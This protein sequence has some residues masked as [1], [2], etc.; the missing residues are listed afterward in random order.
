MNYSLTCKKCNLNLIDFIFVENN[1]ELYCKCLPIGAIYSKCSGIYIQYNGTLQDNIYIQF[2]N[3]NPTSK[4]RNDIYYIYEYTNS[5]FIITDNFFQR[6]FE[7]K[8][9]YNITKF[10][11]DIIYDIVE[12]IF[13]IGNKFKENLLFL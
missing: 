12:E 6:N 2:C 11:K 9:N 8:F 1:E 10:S 3:Y 13:I 4:T 5:K 7:Y